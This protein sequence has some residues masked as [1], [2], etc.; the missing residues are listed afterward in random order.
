[1]EKIADFAKL[2]VTPDPLEKMPGPSGKKNSDHNLDSDIR[3]R[4][5]NS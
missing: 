2:L 4:N 1:M 5:H 3:A